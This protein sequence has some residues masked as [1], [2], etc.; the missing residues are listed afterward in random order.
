MR[1]KCL[2]RERK[3]YQKKKKLQ[4]AGQATEK[5]ALFLQGEDGAARRTFTL[6]GGQ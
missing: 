3:A 5:R 4:A 2:E 1:R 6:A